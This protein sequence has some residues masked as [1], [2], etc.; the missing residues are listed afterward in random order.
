[1]RP[2]RSYLNRILRWAFFVGP[3]R[4]GDES[5]GDRI[6]DDLL[7][8]VGVVAVLVLCFLLLASCSVTVTS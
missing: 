7:N 6:T 5:E 2:R 8:L 1:M 3:N 4:S